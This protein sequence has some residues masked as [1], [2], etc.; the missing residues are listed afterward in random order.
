MK[1]TLLFLSAIAAIIGLAYAANPVQPGSQIFVG[2][3]AQI[4][5][6]TTNNINF[7]DGA[8]PGPMTLKQVNMNGYLMSTA[9]VTIVNQGYGYEQFTLGGLLT[10]A[11]G[12]VLVA[13]SPANGSSLATVQV[14]SGTIDQINAI[15][16]SLTVTAPGAVV[17]AATS[18]FAWALTTGTV[19]PGQVL[20]TTPTA[21]G[22]LSVNAN[23]VWGA[24]I[25][26]ALSTG[27]PTGGLTLV[28]L[29][30]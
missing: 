29:R 1:R 15:G 20:V 4:Y 10:S 9:S 16:I 12:S 19:N 23:S 26:T 5:S 18:G 2:P 3:Q 14:A 11:V 7:V 24:D 6:D 25:A 13:T 17:T 22:Y 30:K 27:T 8:S 21:Y 28:K